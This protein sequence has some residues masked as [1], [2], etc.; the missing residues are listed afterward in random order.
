MYNLTPKD[1]SLLLQIAK[2]RILL[3]DQIVLLNN[4]GK[5]AVQKKVNILYKNGILNFSP[6]TFGLNRGRPENICCLSERGVKLLQ[7]KNLIPPNIP[8]QRVTA[9][10][11]YNIEHEILA[12]WFQ[13]Y[14]NLI[15]Q[16]SP[17]LDTEFLSAKSPFLPLKKN[18]MPG[19]VRVSL[20]AY[21]SEKEVNIFLETI[22][23]ICKKCL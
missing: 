3:I 7:R 20:G 15:S 21:N 2:H 10:G 11:L 4:T 16:R 1:R 19:M 6:R 18:G 22:E 13:I 12:I 23:Y 14:L 9:E 8:I 17:D 5:R